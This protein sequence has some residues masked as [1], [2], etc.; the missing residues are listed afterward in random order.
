MGFADGHVACRMNLHDVL[1]LDAGSRA[2]GIMRR[3]RQSHGYPER[4]VVSALP[5]RLC[6]GSALQVFFDPSNLYLKTLLDGLVE[7]PVSPEGRIGPRDGPPSKEEGPAAEHR[8]QRQRA[9]GAPAHLSISRV[10]TRAFETQEKRERG[11]DVALGRP[12]PKV[13]ECRSAMR[14]AGRTHSRPVPWEGCRGEG[15]LQ[16]RSKTGEG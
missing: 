15:L 8:C 5:Q 2:S 12:P 7:W 9:R 14:V 13:C 3:Q 6:T 10:C 16:A 11:C 1:S 4:R